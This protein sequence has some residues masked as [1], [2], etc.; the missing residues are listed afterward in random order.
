MHA[1]QRFFVNDRDNTHVALPGLPVQATLYNSSPYVSL[2]SPLT[3][4]RGKG[5]KDARCKEEY[6]GKDPPMAEEKDPCI[7][8]SDMDRWINGRAG[9]V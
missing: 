8:G 7:R 6:E 3:L 4:P 1:L 2:H 5:C 9:I